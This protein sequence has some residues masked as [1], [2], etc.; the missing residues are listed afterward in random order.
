MISFYIAVMMIWTCTVKAQDDDKSIIHKIGFDVRPSYVAPTSKF[1]KDDGYGNGLTLRK[2]ASFHLK[3]GFQLNPNSKEGQLYPH[4]YQGIGVSYNTFGNRQEVGNPWAAYVFQAP[5]SP[6]ISSRLS[7]DYEWNFGASFGW[8]PYDDNNNYRNK[9]IGS[10]INAYINLGFFPQ[11][12]TIPLLQPCLSG[13]I[14]THYSN[15][16]SSSECGIEYD[17]WPDRTRL[18]AQSYRGKPS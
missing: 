7:F 2:A 12:E 6:K 17:W 9:I 4:T 8:H 3:Y 14:L 11:R 18:H 1:L 16:I 13:R 15:G 10:K 5:A